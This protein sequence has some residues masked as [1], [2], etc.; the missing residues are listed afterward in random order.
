MGLPVDP[1]YLSTNVRLLVPPSVL[2]E[3]V[4]VAVSEYVDVVLGKVSSLDLERALQPIVDNVVRLVRELA[5]LAVATAPHIHAGSLALFDARVSRLLRRLAAGQV[6]LRLPVI[7]VRDRDVA[8]VA[9]V[10]TAGLSATAAA[11]LRP[12]IAA[13][14]AIGDLAGALALVVPAYLD[15]AA[16]QQVGIH[17]SAGAARALHSLP[18]LTTEATPH[19]VL[20][21]GLDRL[22]VLALLL[23]LGLLHSLLDSSGRRLRGVAATLGCATGL[24]LLSGLVIRAVVVD[25][26]RTGGDGRLPDPAIRRLALDVDHQLRTG[27]ARTFLI[28]V[29]VLALAALGLW[30]LPQVRVGAIQRHRLVTGLVGLAVTAAAVTA[31]VDVATR[32]PVLCNES[33][34]LCDRRYDNVTYLTSH[35]A[36]A[37]SDRGFLI[38]NQDPD[39]LA[40][41]DNGVRGLMLDLHYWTTPARAAPYLASLDPRTAQAL[42]PLLETFRPLP[43]VWLCH[44]LCQLGADPAIPQLQALDQWLRAHPEDVVTLILQDDVAPSDV[45]R[46]VS[47][48]GLEPLLATPPDP[49]QP[50]P[51]LGQLVHDHHTLVVFTQNAELADGPIRNLYDYAAETPYAAA[52]RGSLSCA[53]GRGPASAPIFLIN[54]WIDGLPTRAHALSVDNRSFLLRRIRRCQTQRALRATF[55]AVDFSQVGGPLQVVD[56]LN[57]ASSAGSAVSPPS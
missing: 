14:L 16:V 36:M 25:P 43:G 19:A 18:S 46:V 3:V 34:H 53:P 32:A 51:T 10:L 5:P 44:E 41:L 30:L 45:R 26:L 29:A 13:L 35:N 28:L 49:G 57:S 47:D 11:G 15:D 2:E 54:N 31:F 1:S 42:S 27:V 21:L 6:H 38:A 4:R 20:P 8:R 23:S 56:T 9:D 33:A 48:A 40:Q 37:S 39:L 17:A 12:R 24:A 52:S 22:T 50:W 55:V 7:R